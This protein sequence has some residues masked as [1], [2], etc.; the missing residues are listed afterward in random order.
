VYFALKMAVASARQDAGV[1]RSE[2]QME[3]P[4]TVDVRQQACLVNPGRFVMPY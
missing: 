4:A 2:F 1:G 3:V